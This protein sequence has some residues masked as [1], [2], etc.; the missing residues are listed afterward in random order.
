MSRSWIGVRGVP[1]RVAVSLILLLWLPLDATGQS[2]SL[3]DFRY[4]LLHPPQYEERG[5][6]FELVEYFKERLGPQGWD[7][8]PLGQLPSSNAQMTQTLVCTIAHTDEAASSDSVE[9]TLYGLRRASHSPAKRIRGRVDPQGGSR[10]CYSEHRG[11]TSGDE[12]G[13]REELG[14]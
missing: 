7:F 3:T 8:P 13:V 5:D 11:G 9:L 14:R 6:R 1:L 2:R 10:G 4:M 12:T